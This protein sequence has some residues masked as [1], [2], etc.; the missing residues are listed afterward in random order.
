MIGLLL[1]F[2]TISSASFQVNGV[3]TP[4][5]YDT[6]AGGSTL[7]FNQCRASARAWQELDASYAN[8]MSSDNLYDLDHGPLVTGGPPGYLLQSRRV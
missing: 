5:A 1:S 4:H 8:T 3:G 2:L 6:T 7:Q